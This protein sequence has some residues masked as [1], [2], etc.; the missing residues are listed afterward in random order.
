MDEN[1]KLSHKAI[2]KYET[3]HAEGNSEDECTSYLGKPC[4]HTFHGI[5]CYHLF[6][7]GPTTILIA[8]LDKLLKTQWMNCENTTT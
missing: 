1:H 4:T 2:E 3:H 7:K 6:P 8:F 5:A